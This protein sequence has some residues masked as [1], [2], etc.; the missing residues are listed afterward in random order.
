MLGL[1]KRALIVGTAATFVLVLMYVAMIA[2]LIFA[3][4]SWPGV[5]RHF[6]DR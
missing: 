3:P 2:Y 4:E 1:L 5:E 6:P